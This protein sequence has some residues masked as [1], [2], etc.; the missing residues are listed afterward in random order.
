MASNTKC[1]QKY[2]H[3][4]FATGICLL[5]CVITV[6]QVKFSTI[7]NEKH[8]GISD[9]VQVEYT[10]ENAKSVERI[11]SPP[12]KDF[13]VIQGPV[14][15]NGVSYT[16]GVLSQF[17]SV[18]YIL[19]PLV[20]GKLLVPGAS[21]LIDGKAM[22]S[23]SVVIDVSAVGSN[24][25]KMN[26][27]PGM[28]PVSSQ[29]DTRVDE[30]YLLQPGE[31]L[32]EKI[33]NNLLVKTEVNK[34]TCY[35]GEPIMATFKLCSRLRS[36]SKVL[37]RPSLN[38]FSVYDMVEPEDNNPTI[39]T[40]NGKSF[41]VH[42]IR[43]T[44]LFPLQA[45]TFIIDP[46]EL[47]NTVKFIK[48]N[49]TKTGAKTPMQRMLDE[50]LNEEVSREVQEHSF[51]LASK[52][53]TITVKPLPVANKPAGFNG[54]VG[55]FVMQGRMKNNKV[56][57]GDPMILQLQIKGEGNFTV[58]N[59]PIIPAPEGVEAYDPLIKENIEKTVYPLSGSKTFEYTFIARDTGLYKI[60]GVIF[61]YFDPS[62]SRYRTLRSDSFTIH[63]IP[64]KKRIFPKGFLSADH[65]S[66]PSGFVDSIPLNTFVGV[67]AVALFAALGMY[68]WKKNQQDRKVKSLASSSSRKATEAITKVIAEPLKE[69]RRALLAGKSQQ[70][71]KEVNHAV[72]RTLSE[73]L[74]IPAVELNKSN[75]VFRLRSKGADKEMIFKLESV[76]N[77]CEIS[78]Y[79]PV[80]SLT[81]MEETLTKA[82]AVII[83]L[84]KSL[85]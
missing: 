51:T 32:S 33:K 35:E 44:Q 68:H 57:A 56:A 50:F 40:I 25:N 83:L 48:V 39:Q 24:R 62:G 36:E 1:L 29:Q 65:P 78:L 10:V 63:V 20:P 43:K 82:E 14:Q 38:G 12:F 55:K 61:S 58:I 75:A 28:P 17:K 47:E 5:V 2:L 60:P 4:I 19:Q 21:A 31:S 15:S 81:D 79:T 69:A 27:S 37:K 64:S 76:L 80:H 71:Y 73:K 13:R 46:V 59:P 18:S 9:Y 84:D 23:E 66:T 74:N 70:F 42:I 67:L 53:V 16:N 77:E 34:T 85:T 52:P 54:A 30:E 7:V 11:S 45:G 72:W 6:A 22:R 3:Y 49:S 8:P 26:L 41:N